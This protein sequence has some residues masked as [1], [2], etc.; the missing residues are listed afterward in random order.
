MFGIP[1]F[2][3]PDG[4]LAGDEDVVIADLIYSLETPFV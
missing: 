2:I 4:T 1:G 3:L